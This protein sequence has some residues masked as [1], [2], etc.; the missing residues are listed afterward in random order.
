MSAGRCPEGYSLFYLSMCSECKIPGRLAT[1]TQVTYKKEGREAW[2]TECMMK[3]MRD[4]RRDSEA[5][6]ALWAEEKQRMDRGEEGDAEAAST[7]PVGFAIALPAEVESPVLSQ[8]LLQLLTPI[9][10][11]VIEYGEACPASGSCPETASK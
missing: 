11:N 3:Y 9:S 7:P 8:E 10:R 2:C 4:V 1:R 5:W 6:H